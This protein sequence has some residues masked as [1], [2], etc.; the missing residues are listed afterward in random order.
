MFNYN[1]FCYIVIFCILCVILNKN[2]E[3]FVSTQNK[4]NYPCVPTQNKNKYPLALPSSK[5]CR[6]SRH[7]D[8]KGKWYYKYKKQ[9]G[10]ICKPYGENIVIPNEIT[11]FYDNS[12]NNWNNDNMCKPNSLANNK[13]HLGSC[14]TSHNFCMDFMQKKEC[15]SYPSFFWSEKTCRDNVKFPIE[16]KP[17]QKFIKN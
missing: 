9:E 4:N 8:V 6:V 2:K 11:Y 1:N 16:Y 7:M 12:Y 3:T 5:C 14:R 15:E 10:D 13:S 17:N